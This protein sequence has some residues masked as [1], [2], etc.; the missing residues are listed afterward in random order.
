MEQTDWNQENQ[1]RFQILLI[2]NR[3]YTPEAEGLTE[4]QLQM[5]DNPMVSM[6]F[7]QAETIFN[8]KHYE[9]PSMRGRTSF[10][11]L[12]KAGLAFIIKGKIKITAL[13]KRLLAEEIEMDDFYCRS[14][15]QWQYPNPL[16]R[17]FSTADGYDTKPFISTLQLI[18][19]VNELC[20]EQGHKEKGISK[21]EFGIFALSLINYKEIH[22]AAQE[23]LNFRMKLESIPTPREKNDFQISFTQSY[24]ADYVNYSENNIRDYTD[25]VIRYFRLTKYIYIRGGGYYI[26]L[27]PRRKVELI[28]LFEQENGSSRLFSTKSDFITFMCDPVTYVLPWESIQELQQITNLIIKDIHAIQE[29]L[30]L[31]RGTYVLQDTIES[32]Q[33]QALELREI[34]TNL[35]SKQIKLNYMNVA[36][37]DGTIQKLENIRNLPEKPSIALEKYIHIALNIINDAI[38]IKANC[39][40]GDDNDPIFTAPANVPDIEYE[41]FDFA[42]ICE[43]TMLT[44]RNQW[45]N[46]GQP[47]MR[48]LRDFEEKQQNKPNYCLFV[49]PSL[50]R[51]T[52]NTFWTAIKHEY[53]GKQQRIVPLSISQIV[54]LLRLLQ[55]WIQLGKRFQYS[56]LRSLYDRILNVEGLRSSTEW[57]ASIS[58]TFQTWRQELLAQ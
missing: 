10:K 37:I 31:E 58:T 12:E 9:D 4:E 27:E 1:C 24:L 16:S 48:H 32:L 3:L 25:N 43:V 28:K 49:S 46:E 19:R 21:I 47:V 52:L 39:P 53:E 51:D 56:H 55:K 23:L 34:R 44:G 33:K 2:Q 42:G 17:D 22:M 11:P 36:E 5:L 6:T 29:E 57:Q 26:D 50:H 30:G 14:L 13:G 8:D 38:Q 7:Q 45:Y 15:I 40:V 41:Y 18:H 54:E 35:Q 20:R